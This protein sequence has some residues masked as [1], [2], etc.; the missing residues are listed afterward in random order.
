LAIDMTQPIAT[1][2]EQRFDGKR[3][4]ELFDDRVRVAGSAQL[5]SEFDLS[6]PLHA[7]N[8]EPMRLR[9]RNKAFW[10]GTWLLL[11]SVLGCTVLLS[12]MQVS[13]ASAAFVLVAVVGASGLAL[14]LATARKVE[15]L[16]FQ[17]NAGF[18][19]LAIARSGPDARRLDA[20]VEL[21]AQ[22]IRTAARPCA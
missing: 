21:I 15:F 14:S 19:V 12:A 1:Y 16:A 13:Y 20:F 22:H 9:I 5:S 3:T 18:Q 7:L 6:V 10:A 8:P 17:N 4:F 11:G 2:R